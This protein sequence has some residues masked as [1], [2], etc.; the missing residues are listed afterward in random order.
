MSYDTKKTFFKK[1]S[2]RITFGYVILFILSSSFILLLNYYLFRQSLQARDH[3]LL[4]AKIKEYATVYT[5]GGIE[6]IRKHLVNEKQSDNET[7][8]LVSVLA[9]NGNLIFLHIPEKMQMLSNQEIQDNLIKVQN[10]SRVA[11]FHMK[12]NENS[13]DPNEDNEYET[14]NFKTEDSHVLQVARSTDDREDLL[15]RY[16]R[17]VI[18]AFGFV[19]VIGSLG[20]YFFSNQALAPLRNLIQT[21]KLINSGKL[22]ARVSVRNSNDELDEISV[23]F[24]AMT[25][26]IERV[27][28]NMQE[29]LDQV[30]HDLKTPLT[31]IRTKAEFALLSYGSTEDY[32]VVLANTIENTTE[33]VNF[34]DSIMDISEAQAGIL[35]LNRVE[36]FS[37]EIIQ[38]VIDLFE[39]YAEEKEV[40]IEFIKIEQFTFTADRNRVKQ[41]LVNLLDNAIKYSLKGGLVQIITKKSIQKYQIIFKDN[42]IG[43]SEENKSKIWQRLFRIDNASSVKGLGL[44]L[45]LVESICKAHGWNICV[46]S[47]L[48]V[49][50]EFQIDLST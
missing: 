48:G 33:I 11:S 7:Q 13:E 19:M 17:I 46:K 42:G 1:I 34:V 28:L 14:V 21:M 10:N 25:A 8:F 37:T 20:G 49:G 44:G 22:N 2:F 47:E 50:S 36:V 23:L 45:S 30:A 35:K 16:N 6:A 27:I 5:Q 40:K 26:K 24:N 38:E 32:K 39:Y 29:T 4:R 18:I 3:D 12:E 31:R 9:Q 41:V 43:I 15:E